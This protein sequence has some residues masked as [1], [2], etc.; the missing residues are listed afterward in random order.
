MFKLKYTHTK[1]QLTFGLLLVLRFL[2]PKVV[3]HSNSY[4]MFR[5]SSMQRSSS[6]QCC[7]PS[8]IHLGFSSIHGGLP[9]LS[10]SSLQGCI[11]SKV[12]SHSRSSAIQDCLQS[13][14][15]Y[16]PR[17]SSTKGRPPYKIVF[18]LRL[19]SILGPLQYKDVSIQGC[20]SSKVYFHSSFSPILGHLQSKVV[21]NQRLSSIQGCLPS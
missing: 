15:I 10:S 16:H 14:D 2:P 8:R 12:G 18:H 21:F 4:F 19:I 1:F 5:L 9:H 7:L 17:S 6:I 3:F 11:S 13:K 20:F